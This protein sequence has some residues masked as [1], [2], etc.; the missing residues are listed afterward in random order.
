MGK[1]YY[2][3]RMNDMSKLKT[4]QTETKS[5]SGQTIRL[6]YD[7]D[8]D[9][10]EM[11]FGENEAATGVELTDH[12][13][14]RLNRETGRVVSLTFLHFSILTERTE[15]GPRSYP[16]NDL[17]ELPEELRDLLIRS[18]TAPPISQ[19]LKLSF[20]Q[21]SPTKRV[22]LAYVA[23]LDHPAEEPPRPLHDLAR[24][25]AIGED[26][27]HAGGRP[28]RRAA[29]PHRHGLGCP[30]TVDGQAD[31]EAEDVGDDVAPAS[32]HY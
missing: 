1:I 21:E 13:L 22:P 3:E 2:A 15:Y 16:L 4:H 12:I 10:M 27:P 25:P 8:A 11:F 31:D 6:T 17:D 29:A 20:F 14:L 19:F 32:V 28:G 30:G 24:A 5:E 23:S 9:M 18:V 26:D 7:E